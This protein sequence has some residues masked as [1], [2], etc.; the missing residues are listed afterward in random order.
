V[1]SVLVVTSAGVSATGVLFSVAVSFSVAA[2]SASATWLDSAVL[3]VSVT[4]P[5][6]IIDIDGDEDIEDED[7]NDRVLQIGL[8]PDSFPVRCRDRTKPLTFVVPLLVLDSDRLI[9]GIATPGLA[10]LIGKP[11]KCNVCC[12]LFRVPPIICKP[13]ISIL[14]ILVC[15]GGERRCALGDTGLATCCE[16][17]Q[18]SVSFTEVV[19]SVPDCSGSSI[20]FINLTRRRLCGRPD[21][22]KNIQYL[23][24]C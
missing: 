8:G 19:V 7:V 16:V 4:S 20:Q 18:A 2:A 14:G 5:I 9:A 21:I 12:I 22:V 1:A 23:S 3:S 13:G 11:P 24:L 17:F 10:S 6:F 15:N